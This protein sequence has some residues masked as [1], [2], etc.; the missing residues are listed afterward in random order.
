M[1]NIKTVWHEINPFTPSCVQ[2]LCSASMQQQR[3]TLFGD[4]LCF[5]FITPLASLSGWLCVQGAMDLY[6]TN[7]AEALG[8]L[9]LTLALFIIY[10]F[11][12]MVCAVTGPAV[13]LHDTR[14]DLTCNRSLS[15]LSVRVSVFFFSKEIIGNT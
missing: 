12:S 1:W 8:L 10:V 6:Y 5:L 11:W 7:G 9:V 14:A 2:W 13:Q 15:S 4:T 3:R